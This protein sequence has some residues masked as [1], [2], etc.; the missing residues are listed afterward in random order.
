MIRIFKRPFR[1]PHLELCAAGHWATTAG[2][3]TK[4]TML[5]LRKGQK[6]SSHS[7]MFG[8]T[9]MFSVK[10]PST[11]TGRFVICPEVYSVLQLQKQT[12]PSHH[13]TRP[14]EARFW[15]PASIHPPPA[16][17]MSTKNLSLMF[18]TSKACRI[19]KVR[20]KPSTCGTLLTT[21]VGILESLK[22]IST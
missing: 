5:C 18:T 2:T 1:A 11:H 13:S 8:N 19:S 7:T 16:A 17:A 3:K 10:K 22:H 20:S 9:R 21:I 4:A 15:Y 6:C 12:L 14:V